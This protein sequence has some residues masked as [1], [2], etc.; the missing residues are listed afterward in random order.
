VKFVLL[1]IAVIVLLPLFRRAK[2][3]ETPDDDKKAS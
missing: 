1:A 2:K 3:N